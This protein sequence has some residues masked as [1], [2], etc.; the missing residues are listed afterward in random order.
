[1]TRVFFTKL[2]LFLVFGLFWIICHIYAFEQW[3]T[4]QDLS[5]PQEE[6]IEI[7]VWTW[8]QRKINTEYVWSWENID[9]EKSLE[10]DIWDSIVWI[11]EI[12]IKENNFQE[13]SQQ[14]TGTW[15]N[16]WS[17]GIEEGKDLKPL[18][19]EEKDIWEEE[20]IQ[21]QTE[22]WE[23]MNNIWT[24][25]W[26]E[27]EENIQEEW[28]EDAI[29]LWEQLR[30]TEIYPKDSKNDVGEYIIKEYII[31]EALTSYDGV[32]YIAGLGWWW[33]LAGA[34]EI[35]VHLQ[36]HE[37]LIITDDIAQ[38]NPNQNITLLSSI[39]LTDSGEELQ[40]TDDEGNVLDHVIYNNWATHQ[41]SWYY[42]QTIDNKR[43]FSTIRPY[44]VSISS[45][46]TPTCSLDMGEIYTQDDEIY[47]NLH[48]S[49][50]NNN[51]CDNWYM[52]EW[53]YDGEQIPWD[54]CDHLFVT[55]TGVHTL[56][57]K[58]EQ[59]MTEL[60]DISLDIYNYLGEENA[61]GTWSIWTWNNGG[62]WTWTTGAVLSWSLIKITEIY[63]YDTDQ[64]PEYIEIMALQDVHDILEIGWLGHGGASKTIDVDL[65]SWEKLVVTDSATWFSSMTKIQVLPSLSLTDG[66][67]TLSLFWQ[68]GQV[69]DIY[70][71]S[72]AVRW[73]SLVYTSISSG[74]I[75][76]FDKQIPTP[77][78]FYN[79]IAYLFD[80]QETQSNFDCDIHVQNNTPFYQW[81][82]INLIAI[83]QGKEIQNSSTKYTCSWQF[84]WSE[85]NYYFE[86]CNPSYFAYTDQGM[87]QVMV[88]ITD[89]EGKV[90]S[91]SLDINYP[92][93]NSGGWWNSGAGS[94]C[95]QGYYEDLYHKRKERYTFLKKDVTSLWYGVTTSGH[96]YEKTNTNSDLVMNNAVLRIVSL[97]P[98]PAW[99]D[100][101]HER[102]MLENM[103]S[104]VIVLD[105]FSTFNGSSKKKL[106]QGIEIIPWETKEII[107][108]LWLTN[109]PTCLSLQDQTTL[110]DTFC[111]PQAS[112]DERFVESLHLTW[113][114]EQG[115]L[116]ILSKL[117]LHIGDEQ[118][119]VQYNKE[120]FLCK[121][122]SYSDREV[123]ERKDQARKLSSAEKSL[124]RFQEKRTKKYDTLQWRFKKEQ[125]KVVNEQ[126]KTE[127]Q[128]SLTSWYQKQSRLHSAFA[129]L[130]TQEL[131][132]K[133]LP[134]Y[135]QSVLQDYDYIYQD[136]LRNLKYHKY[137]TSYG[138]VLF[139]TEDI[140]TATKI[141]LQDTLP[142]D[143]VSLDAV[144]PDLFEATENLV[145]T[146]VDN[147]K[148]HEQGGKLTMKD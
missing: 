7:L 78:L 94:S 75:Q 6:N 125:K 2:F 16:I 21:T 61:C 31:L 103:G 91:T 129:M 69:I 8:I 60:C 17:G 102:L 133:R 96:V 59:W 65:Y 86:G 27:Q 24:W 134:L 113:A 107:G 9:K 70:T 130:M 4:W 97:L 29:S 14:I 47:Y 126:G 82:K 50:W 110:Y 146:F 127:K 39:T 42:T 22:P 131:K 41:Q 56:S 43:S 83:A 144:Y 10:E 139:K 116:D 136:L 68:S 121:D 147:L 30:I 87:Y 145:D 95:R 12:L 89:R 64:F 48:L 117:K 120:S 114:E 53:Y 141:Q 26:V 63:P 98:N 118:A 62:T 37:H 5:L 23:E 66:W 90:C 99:A 38:L 67:E 58:L 88:N 112:D 143:Q 109:R 115:G 20:T 148:V 1:M 45:L 132:E 85:D 71:Y 72:G 101:D 54:T 80:E 93:K 52:R 34:K 106:P 51:I 124:L 119:C 92:E 36:A 57:V 140:L 49:G 19:Q 46:S 25:L 81:N 142:L 105:T 100:S 73:E 28:E 122:L 44:S 84:P 55:S 74:V 108:S 111:Y 138:G 13:I 40:I 11:N 15:E 137:V 33:H 104:W 123:K 135:H 128:K 18:E 35:E 77:W 3:W 76:F 79:Q 32:I